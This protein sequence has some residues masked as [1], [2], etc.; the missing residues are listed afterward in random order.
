MSSG[1]AARSR[2][3]DQFSVLDNN[4]D[5]THIWYT[6]SL[7]GP[8]DEHP[9]TC[10]DALQTTH[11]YIRRLKAYYE[12]DAE[13]IRDSQFGFCID[14]D[15]FLEISLDS[16]SEFRIRFEC[17]TEKSFIGLKRKATFSREYR[18]GQI[19]DLDSIVHHFFAFDLDQFKAYFIQQNLPQAGAAI[20]T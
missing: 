7:D 18:T 19:A 5:K 17:Q 14:K 11:D 20:H 3:A 16:K 10:A 12:T 15:N 8:Q 6:M 13:L 1:A 2:A 9:V 4:M